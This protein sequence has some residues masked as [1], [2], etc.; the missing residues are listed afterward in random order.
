MFPPFDIVILLIDIFDYNG[1]SLK[2]AI[3]LV[4]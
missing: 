4:W 1:F 2:Y 3:P